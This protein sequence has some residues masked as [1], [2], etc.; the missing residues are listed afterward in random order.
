M[1]P[2]FTATQVCQ[3]S[4]TQ[5]QL[6]KVVITG[7]PG[8]GKSAILEMARMQFCPHVALLPESATILFSGG[9][10]RENSLH[11][12]EVAQRAIFHIQKEMERFV[13]IKKIYSL[14]ICDRGTLDGLAYW[15]KTPKSFFAALGISRKEELLNYSVV[16]HLR[17]PSQENGYNLRNPVRVETAKEAQEMDAKLEKAWKGHPQ[18]YFIDSTPNFM[19]KAEKTFQ[20]LR[21]LIPSCCATPGNKHL[22][23][24]ASR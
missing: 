14:A 21:Q 7:G 22:K 8:A 3:C 1:T 5:H 16:I 20:I 9:F 4:K 10:W 2:H 17:T 6:R 11:G 15:P 23:F 19:E 13:L 24:S 18:R 12:R